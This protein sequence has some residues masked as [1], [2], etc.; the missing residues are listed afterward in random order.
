MHLVAS[1]SPVFVAANA[2]FIAVVAAHFDILPEEGIK[3]A[4]SQIEYVL[5][6][7][8]GKPAGRSFMIGYGEN[9]PKQP[10]HVAA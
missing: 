2:A 6:Q 3:F 5:G 7:K 4:G 10:R 8:E 9:W 1:H